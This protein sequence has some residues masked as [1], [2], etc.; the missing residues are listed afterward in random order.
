[1]VQIGNFD[2][3]KVEPRQSFDPLPPGWYAAQVIESEIRQAK[4]SDNRYLQLT[5]ELLE[6]HHPEYKGRRVWER[7]NRWNPNETTVEIAERTLSGICRSVGLMAITDS[8]QLHFKPLA[9][10]LKVKQSEGY[11]AKNEISGY[12]ALAAR[13]GGGATPSPAP[14]SK[15]AQGKTGPAAPP[16]KKK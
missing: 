4:E 8:E 13:F 9:I 3:S 7:L 12:D 1:M 5:L 14:A 16:W 2:A 15:P 10:K 6:S 11:D